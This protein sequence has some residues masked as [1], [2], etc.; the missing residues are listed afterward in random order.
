MNTQIHRL[1]F[2]KS[3]GCLIAIGEYVGGNGGGSYSGARGR[4]HRSNI[5]ALGNLSVQGGDV[6][7]KDINLIALGDVT[8]TGVQNKQVYAVGRQHQDRVG[9]CVHQCRRRKNG[10]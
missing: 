9:E 8:L 4:R 1:V 7:A 6:Q 5:T 10:Q 2:N 3:I